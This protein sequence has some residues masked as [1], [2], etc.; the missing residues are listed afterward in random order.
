MPL[1][2]HFVRE[3][4]R[5]GL[6]DSIGRPNSNVIQ[7][8]WPYDFWVDVFGRFYGRLAKIFFCWSFVKI[9]LGQYFK[10]GFSK[11]ASMKGHLSYGLRKNLRAAKG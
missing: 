1:C 11:I 2:C 4:T 7:V 9:R 10:P 5:P 6:P 8:G 3:A